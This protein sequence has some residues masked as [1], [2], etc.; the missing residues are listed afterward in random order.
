MVERR[1][2]EV[3]GLSAMDGWRLPVLLYRGSSDRPG[4]AADEVAVLASVDGLLI[5]RAADRMARPGDTIATILAD[6][7][8]PG[9]A[10]GRTLSN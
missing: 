5:I 3:A 4:R 9:S 8:V 7:P 1:W 2:E 10:A 6:R